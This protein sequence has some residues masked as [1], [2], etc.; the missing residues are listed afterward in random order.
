[1][2]KIMCYHGMSFPKKYPPWGGIF[3]KE[4]TPLV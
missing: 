1:M 4:S 2:V 3:A